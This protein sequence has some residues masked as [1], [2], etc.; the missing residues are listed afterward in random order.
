MHGRNE[1]LILDLFVQSVRLCSLWFSIQSKLCFQFFLFAMLS[2]AYWTKIWPAKVSFYISTSGRSKK[3]LW[4][5]SPEQSRD[6]FR[7]PTPFCMSVSQTIRPISS[8]LINQYKKSL[9]KK[10]ELFENFENKEQK[11]AK[12]RRR[13][14]YNQN[15]K[16]ELQKTCS[17]RII[18]LKKFRRN[19]YERR[20]FIKI[21]I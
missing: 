13:R 3:N 19:W 7:E 21:F 1:K 6:V 17:G 8:G 20:S 11:R 12:L 15:L 10:H 2:A 9:S 5:Q 4:V 16:T 18:F 14:F